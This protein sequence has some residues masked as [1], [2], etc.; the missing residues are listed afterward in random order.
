MLP[1]IVDP[2]RL[3][4]AAERS[5]TE[6]KHL[7]TDPTS[8]ERALPQKH[9]TNSLNNNHTAKNRKENEV[10]TRTQ[11]T[12]ISRSSKFPYIRFSTYMYLTLHRYRVPRPQPTNTTQHHHH[13]LHKKKNL[14]PPSSLPYPTLPQTKPNQTQ[15]QTTNLTNSLPNR[16]SKPLK[17]NQQLLDLPQLQFVRG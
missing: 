5:R 12:Y 6:R 9:G 17:L 4:G 13:R 2:L 8:D 11:S 3:H 16:P 14:L 15:T 7:S 1:Y 10:Y